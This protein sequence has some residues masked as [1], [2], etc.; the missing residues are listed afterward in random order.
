MRSRI[1]SPSWPGQEAPLRLC[2]VNIQVVIETGG[3]CGMEMNAE[4]TQ[5]TRIE[6]NQHHYG[7]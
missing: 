1:S 7:L 2:A 5:V 4:K 6:G 3:C